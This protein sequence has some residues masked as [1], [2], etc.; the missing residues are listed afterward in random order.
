MTISNAQYTA[1]LAADGVTRE[2]LVEAS[3]NS[4]SAEVTR[5]LS[6][7]GYRSGAG[8]SPANT[9]YASRLTGTLSLARSVSISNADPSVQMIVSSIDIDNTDGALDSWLNDAWEKRTLKV[10]LGDPSWARADFRQVFAGRSAM[11]KPSGRSKLSLIVYDEMQRLNFSVSETTLGG[12]TANK[13]A[14]IP[15]TWGEAFNVTPLLTNPATHEYQVHPGVIESVLEARDNGA[16]IS[17]TATPT[18]GKFT[19]S[20]SPVGTITCDVQGAKTVSGSVYVKSVATI[21][22]EL[23]TAYGDA[24]TRLSAGEVDS[25]V[26]TAFDS[27]N[28]QSVGIFL[29]GKTNVLDA[30][31]QV[32]ASVQGSVHFSRAGLL[33]LWRPPT[34]V[35]SPIAT[36]GTGEMRDGSF[37]AVEVLPAAP[38]VT[39]GW[40]KNWTPDAQMAG[41][42][43]E[44]SVTELKLE[45][46]EVAVK[47]ATACTL[48]RYTTRPVRE[49][50][51]LVVDTEA[52]TEANKRLTFRTTGHT[53]IEFETTL[54]AMELE[55]GDAIT[56]VHPRF[57]CS[58][59]K[60]GWVIGTTENLGE[61]GSPFRVKLEVLL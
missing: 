10:F 59:G 14:V 5:Y 9:G 35:G 49:E 41:G 45:W 32:A 20:A 12:T 37:V 7:F 8:D 6:K 21:I 38:A 54:K 43:A 44:T 2:V 27:A 26:F 3:C 61:T 31:N 28:P 42:V 55:L 19:L 13:D 34:G 36:F 18:T 25:T 40:G 16:P 51:L 23:A 22:Q 60:T 53:I 56:V 48:R 24:T 1:W 39:L 17:I 58:A 57:G 11:L 50:T 47:D 30:C 52:T 15:Q 29:S 46:R 33:R 4:S